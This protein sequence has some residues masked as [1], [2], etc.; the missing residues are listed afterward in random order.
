MSRSTTKHVILSATAHVG[1]V[2][3]VL[4]LGVPATVHVSRP[5][6]QV[7]LLAPVTKQK[8]AALH[9]R[10]PRSATSRSAILG[11]P[12]RTMK[13]RYAP[14]AA[15]T[16]PQSL[17]PPA[18]ETELPLPSGDGAPGI[19][20]PDSQG[21]GGGGQGY[22]NSNSC[23]A[24]PDPVEILSKP[25]PAYSPEAQELHLEGDVLLQVVFLASG[26]IRFVRV[27][28]S[29]GHG[30][31]EAAM[32]AAKYIRFKPASCAGVAMDVIATIHVN[33]R[34][35]KRQQPPA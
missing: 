1:L 12:A 34:L 8:P 10:V 25:K 24:Q 32:E 22:S 26:E 31:D 4:A 21:N 27:T 13:V 15:Q 28:R 9:V 6:Q 2:L 17:T 30:L 29:L 5:Y 23:R 3:F 7:V 18:I 14:A 19:W 35:I 16:P 11:S 33:F 20:G